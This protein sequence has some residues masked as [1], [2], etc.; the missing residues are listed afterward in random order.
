MV[1][2]VTGSSSS[3]STQANIGPGEA[4][5]TGQ[6]YGTGPYGGPLPYGGGIVGVSIRVSAAS[7][8][9]SVAGLSSRK[10]V[11]ASSGEKSTT[12]SSTK[13]P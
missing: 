12:G 1:I 3:K 10:S 9:K 5:T 6:G 2:V 7:N 13:E 4:A 11:T 8:E